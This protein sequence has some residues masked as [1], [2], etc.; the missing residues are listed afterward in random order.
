MFQS[1]GKQIGLNVRLHSVSAA[2]YIDF[3]TD[4]KARAGIDGFF[5]V[6]YPDYADP[7]ALYSTLVLPDG[8]QNY[9]GFSDSTIT[10]LME[11]AR[12]T[13]DPTARAKLVVRAQT[14]IMQELPWIP[15]ADPDSIL[16]LNRKLTGAPASFSY[17]FAPWIGRLGAAG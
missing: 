17:M 15:V 10:R 16:I 8:S 7:A 6:N 5:T 9:D 11:Q 4:P 14:R 1:A 3:F 2:N 12:T 13:A